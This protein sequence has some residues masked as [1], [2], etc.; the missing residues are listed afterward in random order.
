MLQGSLRIG[1]DIGGTFTDF[2]VFSPGAGSI[3]TFK[4]LSTPE[5]P[6]RAVLAG[7]ERIARE[8]KEAFPSSS[9]TGITVVHGS[10]VGTN[11][12]LERK[13]ALT[14]LITTDGFADIL[15]I[16]R[17]DRPALYDFSADRPSPLVPPDL[18]FEL[19]ERVDHRGKT[20]KKLSPSS[21]DDLVL[22]LKKRGVRSAAVCFLF[23]FLRPEHERLVEKKLRAAGFVVSVSCEILPEYREYERMST[24][25]VN[26]YV[27]PVMDAYLSRLDDGLPAGTRL[28]IM[29]SNGGNISPAQARRNAVRC[30]LSGPAGGIVGCEHVIRNSRETGHFLPGAG[31]VSSKVITFDMGGTS[32]DVSLI[33]EK[34]RITTEAMVSGCP[35]HI[36]MLDI[37]TIGAGGGSIAHMDAGGALCVGPTSAGADPGPA[38][39]GRGRLPTVTDANL[40]LGRLPGET[41]L[42]GQMQ[43]NAGRAYEALK[44]LGTSHK[45]S[46]EQ[47]A[48]GVVRVVNAHMER[49]LRVISV[50]RGHDP[51]DFTLLSFGGAGGLHAA[52]LARG[53]GI[54]RVLVPPMAS[55]LS[56]FGML[57]ADVIKDYTQTVMLPDSTPTGEI[58]EHLGTMMERGVQEV[59]QEGIPLDRIWAEPFADMRYRGQSYELIVPF[60]RNYLH[61]FHHQHF[62]TY[63]YAQED[64][65]VEIVN[66]RL[67]V[68]GS[69]DALPIPTSPSGGIDPSPA[70]INTREVIFEDAAR[71]T[72]FFNAERLQPCNRIEGPAVIVRPDTT[73]LLNQNDQVTVDA[74][75]N[76]IIEVGP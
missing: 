65:P 64:L 46:P 58:E 33:D 25:V 5:D 34:P 56:A 39:Y 31:S 15:Q 7:L 28:R 54:P 16:G 9:S 6:A 21:V 52:D 1:V 22:K 71:C 69:S 35:I 13:G 76:L 73:I 72:P 10:T 17:Q 38:C 55:T 47:A 11:A 59:E 30:I 75:G 49:A 37:H 67:R 27:S 4:L 18:C 70:F 41:F 43:L 32:T 44:K 61:D 12:L 3:E 24:T 57:A 63:G 68:T 29:Q 20:L 8:H 74:C 36:P 51:R 23:S 42:G 48:L 19:P 40:V 2:A 66:L 60:S 50:E 14:A 62:E 26:A 45:L 53:L